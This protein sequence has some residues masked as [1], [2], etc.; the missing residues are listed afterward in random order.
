MHCSARQIGSFANIAA[1][2]GKTELMQRT[3][4][5]RSLPLPLVICLSLTGLLLTACGST[6]PAR[7]YSIGVI[8]YY[9]I[10]EPVLASFKAQMAALGYVEG[11]NVTYIYHG[12]LKN[13]PEVLGGEVKRLVNQ[14]VD[15]LLTMG[16]QPTLAAKQGVAGTSIPV[17]FVPVTNPVQA[18]VVESVAH[19]GGNVTGVQIVN[20]TPKAVEWLLKLVPGT[21]MVYVPYHPADKVAVTTV[22]LLQDAAARLGVELW[23]NEVQT[24]EEVLTAI[25]TLP[26]GAAILFIPMPSVTSH[27]SAMSKFAMA[28]GIPVGVSAT[29]PTEDVLFAY[30]ANPAD[31]GKQAAR[32][33]A[34]I[35]KGKKPG[36][37][38]VETA[39][40]FLKI[41]LKTATALGL[42]IPDELLRQADTVLR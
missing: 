16:T 39:E 42:D 14:N 33:V 21:K 3:R 35:L 24:Q 31:Q 37:L 36:D 20:G 8:N 41:N 27:M 19:P 1:Q 6:T 18:G 15:L 4:P 40:F 28:R 22:Q 11:N 2:A 5:P 32:L 25:E 34:Q 26:K 9:Q 29:L 10:L 17:V 30:V 7:T 12:V 13:D 38:F 23:L